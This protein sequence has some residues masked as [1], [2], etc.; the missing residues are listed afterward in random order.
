MNYSPFRASFGVAN[1]SKSSLTSSIR[2]IKVLHSSTKILRQRFEHLYLKE[3]PQVSFCMTLSTRS[4]LHHFDSISVIP[5]MI[6]PSFTMH[7][8]QRP[9]YVAF[10]F[11]PWT[12]LP[13]IGNPTT[14]WIPLPF[15]RTKSQ[16]HL[17]ASVSSFKYISPISISLFSLKSNGKTNS[18]WISVCSALINLTSKLNHPP[19]TAA[20]LADWCIMH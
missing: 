20:C 7:P 9:I 19:K 6:L 18:K 11:C 14:L 17:A 5:Y 3:P 12:L 13:N 1:F 15:Y 10:T 2:G 4:T 8:S 16:K